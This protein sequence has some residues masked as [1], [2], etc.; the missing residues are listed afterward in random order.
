MKNNDLCQMVKM[1]DA[2]GNFS[3]KVTKLLLPLES[4]KN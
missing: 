4:D 1:V 2:P 3:L